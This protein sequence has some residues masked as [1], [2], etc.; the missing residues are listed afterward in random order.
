MQDPKRMKE[1]FGGN[2]K[3]PEGLNLQSKDREF[4]AQ[5]AKVYNALM[6]RPMTMK[7]ADIYTGV[8]RENICRYISILL[9]Q[10]RIAMIKKRRCSITGHN[11]V[12]E[13]TANSEL[14]PKPNQLELF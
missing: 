3:S 8:M 7:E 10:G 6:V 11:H 5:L 14:F 12:M 13:F 2:K 9:E 4:T 1:L